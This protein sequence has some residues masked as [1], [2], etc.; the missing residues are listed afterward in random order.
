MTSLEGT[1][2][3]ARVVGWPLVVCGLA[4]AVLLGGAYPGVF[5]PS[6]R[7]IDVG[8]ATAALMCWLVL[9]F[10]HSQWR[11]ATNLWPAITAVLI[12]FTVSTVTSVLPR[13]SLEYLAYTIVLVALYL[14]LVRLQAHPFIGP[15]LNAIALV[16]LVTIATF[17]LSETVKLWQAWWAI[18]GHP[19]LPPLR[20]GFESLA[21]GNPSALGAA[22]VLLFV[23]GAAHFDL[24]TRRR[25]A[26]I[27]ALGVLT[28][29]VCVITGARSVWLG[30]AGLVATMTVLAAASQARRANLTKLLRSGRIRVVLIVGLVLGGLS[31]GAVAPAV[32]VRI[33]SGD[34]Y[35]PGYWAASLR[36]FAE[37][38]ISG[39]GLGVWPVERATFTTPGDVDFYIP[40][41]H[42]VYLQTLG[43]L[44]LVGLV[45]GMIVAWI[46][47]RLLRRSLTGTPEQRRY[48]W[49]TIGAIAYLAAH[50]LVDVVTN[51]P[52]ILL[53]L[54]LP[55]SRMDAL[56]LP[57]DAGKFAARF[58]WS[59][60]SGALLAAM[61]ALVILATATLVWTTSTAARH[62]DAVDS[63]N[64]GDWAAAL[65][66]A[67]AAV[68]ADP[69]MP[70]YRVTLGLALARSGQ[71][72]LAEH[73][74]RTAAEVD[75]LP[76]SWLDIAALD[77][78]LGRTDDARQ[79]LDRALRLGRQQ[80]GV[81]LPASVL[82][83]ELGDHE[84]ASQT[85]ADALRAAPSIAG[86]TWWAARPDLEQEHAAAVQLVITR[87]GGP[88][89]RVALETNQLTLA[90]TAIGTMNGDTSTVQLALE[91]WSGDVNAR[92]E[93]EVKAA[94][95]PLDLDAIAWNAVVADHL[96]DATARNRYRHWAEIVNGGA[97]WEAI[98]YRIVDQLTPSQGPTGTL[99]LTYG[100]YLY[101]RPIPRDELLPGLPQLVYR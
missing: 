85:L 45:A 61:A 80:A 54:V 78:E 48:A 24:S 47:W 25:A 1:S 26:V 5:A 95:Q 59:S 4:Y 74:L 28:V 29:L 18:V 52:V 31:I 27:A 41:A 58:G 51:M 66:G 67:Q 53:L 72:D 6:F 87:G 3:V 42:N 89:F 49:A 57:Q 7:I 75:D 55:I 92:R 22:S 83:V 13:I 15:R 2:R 44:G 23:V 20:P 33:G 71:S 76:Q 77:I 32:L 73:Q 10:V 91:A 101:L 64:S 21:F 65:D 79:A 8:L 12:A 99:G 100:Q 34:P 56:G 97:G 68:M 90:A 11:P 43:E 37:Q 63:A 69:G 38:P 84:V 16:L 82:Y 17:Y 62:Q 40:H 35:R 86:D 60:R 98:G 96:G 46:L 94:S 30:V 39:Q 9:S 50:Q 19:T 36:M 14:L 93:L 88:A 70:P 81:A